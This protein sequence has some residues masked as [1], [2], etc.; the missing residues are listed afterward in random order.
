VAYLIDTDV[1]I[2]L[3]DGHVG[4]RLLV[5]SLGITPAISV[6]TR[7][8]LEG[9]IY[10][11]DDLA[12]RRRAAVDL[13]LGDMDVIDVDAAIADAYGRIVKAVG[14]SRRKIADRI[15]A[16]SAIAHGLTFATFNARDYRD[17]PGLALLA[18]D[19]PA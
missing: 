2:H 13:L 16:A 19:L 15:I 12:A 14:F 8:E 10:A 11:R 3:R 9:G 18:W 7:I 17:I 6:M 1:A 5:D 4:I